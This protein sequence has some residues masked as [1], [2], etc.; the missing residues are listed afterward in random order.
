MPAS[1]AAEAA[2][3]ILSH[4]LPG[5]APSRMALL[6]ILSRVEGEPESAHLLLADLLG[7]RRADGVLA[8]SAAVA[9]AFADL[10]QPIG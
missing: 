3:A 8:S 4:P 10:G 2:S 6:A 1:P 5:A 7:T 9:A